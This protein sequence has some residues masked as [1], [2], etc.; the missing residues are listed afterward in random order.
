MPDK[1]HYRKLIRDNIPEKI[2]REGSEC[3]TRILSDQ[4]YRFELRRKVVEEASSIPA[5]I[6]RAELLD[7]MADLE[8]VIAALKEVEGITDDEMRQALARNR[9]R[10]GGF[11]KR[12]F[13]EWSS[14]SGY[15][16]NEQTT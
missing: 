5:L 10:K 13:L 15:K 6:H 1:I 4:E 14:D 11:E 12:L 16:S 3:E 2:A 7:E 9:E 8:M